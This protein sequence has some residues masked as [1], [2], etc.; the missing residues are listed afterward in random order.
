MKEVLFNTHDLALIFTMFICLSFSV[1]LITLKKGNKLSNCLLACFL[2]TQAAIPLDNL[3]NFGEAFRPF[4]LNLSP[5]LF[6]TFGLAFWLEVPLLL[7]YIKS[8]VNKNYQLQKLDTLLF[9]PFVFYATYFT[10]DWLMAENSIKLAAL[11]QNNIETTP[12]IDRS[13]YFFRECFRFSISVLCFLELQKYQNNIKNEFAEL[14]SVDLTW[15]K[16][17]VIG[18]LAVHL[19]AIFV[20]LGIIMSYDIGIIV[21]H[22]LLGLTSNY[23][24]L[25]LITSLIFFSA[26]HSKIFQG[27]DDTLISEQDKSIEVFE[28]EKIQKIETYLLQNKP[29]LNHLLTLDNL[30]S[31]LSMGS[32]NLSSI[33][34]RHFGKNF[35][36]FINYYRVEE[37]KR[38]LLLEENKTVT[39][40]DIMDKAGFNSKATFNTFFKKLVGITPTQFR[41][42]YWENKNASSPH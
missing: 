3:I 33:I 12:L 22:E 2:L 42:E 24:V 9:I 15:L 37:S 20:S 26:G 1:F 30:A 14:E 13:I 10:V 8:L 21:D 32:R 25:L 5:N 18:F 28:P 4:A 6:Y 36:E 17:L 23:A 11:K 29:Y 40:L 27:I 39:M 34:N 35:F 31:Q 7:L 19:N 41:K 38:L 16:V